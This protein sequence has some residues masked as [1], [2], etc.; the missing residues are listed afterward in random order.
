M[1]ILRIDADAGT[2]SSTAIVFSDDGEF[3][4]KK[5][6]TFDKD[7]RPLKASASI[8]LKRYLVIS[9]FVARMDNIRVLRYK[10]P[11][12]YSD[13]DVQPAKYSGTNLLYR[14]G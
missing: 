10:F 6:I 13:N 3:S 8:F 1:P 14:I 11:C 7:A 5:Y 9:D 2:V 4:T 12:I